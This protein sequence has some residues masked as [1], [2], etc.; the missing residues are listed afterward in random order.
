MI[1]IINIIMDAFMLNK[2]HI[3]RVR[4]KNRYVAI[5]YLDLEYKI[6]SLK[7]NGFS[8]L[9]VPY[10]IIAQKVV[11]SSRDKEILASSAS[12]TKYDLMYYLKGALAGGICCSITHGALCPVDVVKTR[13]QLDPA[14]YNKGLIGGFKQ[15]I[16]EEG[17]NGLAT[18]LGPTVVGYFI[19]G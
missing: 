4:S 5:E 11:N 12:S 7:M 3:I 13:I 19:Q 18:G 6:S 16:A 8:S 17:M 2:I 15:V 9:S 10:S 14:K 1:N